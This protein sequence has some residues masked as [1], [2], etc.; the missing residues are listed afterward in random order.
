M[1][2]TIWERL[3]NGKWEHNHYEEGYDETRTT[4][5]PL[6]DNHVKAWASA[7]WRPTKGELVDGKLRPII[8]P[9]KIEVH[10]RG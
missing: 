8:D 6:H 1:I 9:T 5:T 4:P 10:Y 7:T 3:N 2:V